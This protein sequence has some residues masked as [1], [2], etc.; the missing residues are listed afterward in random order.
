MRAALFVTFRH[1]IKGNWQ[2]GHSDFVFC[3][4]EGGG[5]DKANL[6]VSFVLVVVHVQH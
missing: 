3:G 5:R 6:P 4:G 2:P 1:G